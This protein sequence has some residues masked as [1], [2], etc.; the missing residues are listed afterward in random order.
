MHCLVF[1]TVQR[2]VRAIIPILILVH[3][4]STVFVSF[5][6]CTRIHDAFEFVMVTY[7]VFMHEMHMFLVIQSSI[8]H[9]Y[10]ADVPQCAVDICRREIQTFTFMWVLM[11]VQCLHRKMMLMVMMNQY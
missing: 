4:H 8:L 7:P 6:M 10:L 11:L 1:G 9:T 5:A 2:T 3:P